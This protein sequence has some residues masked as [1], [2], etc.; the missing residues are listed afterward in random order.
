[1]A[2]VAAFG[3]ILLRLS[4][5]NGKDLENSSAF[6]ACYGGTEANVLACLTALGHNTE[7]LTALPDTGLGSGALNRL[8]SLGIHTT[9]AK[10]GGENLGLYFSESGKGSRGANVIYYRSTSEVTRLAE[11]DFDYGKI[12]EGVS[13]F[14]VSGISFALSESCTR[15]AFRFL[16]EAKKRN[17]PVSFDFNYRSKLWTIDRAKPVY[18]K[19]MPFAD[20][21]LLSSLDLSAFL[22]TTAEGCLEKYGTKLVVVRDRKA[23]SPTEHEVGVFAITKDETVKIPTFRFPVKEKIGGGDAFN[24]GFLHGYLAGMPLNEAIRFALSCF[25]LKHTVAGDAFSPKIEDILAYGK[26]LGVI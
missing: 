18:R 21:A 15:V 11:S 20:I 25:T 16:E 7:Y 12:L 9:Y 10:I 6:G 1:M 2:T 17:I 3:E 24:G 13:L 4:A 19:I 26:S 23:L 8:H 22:D 14:H 5:E